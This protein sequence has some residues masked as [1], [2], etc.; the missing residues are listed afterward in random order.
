MPKSFSTIKR[1][2]SADEKRERALDFN[3][4]GDGFVDVEA[5][6]KKDIFKESI[7]LKCLKCDYQEEVDYDIVSEC[8]DDS[9]SPYPISY[10]PHC[11][12]D[13]FVPLDIYNQLKK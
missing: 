2:L 12:R 5:F 10:C 9:E 1:P 11:G 7:F 8:W 4:Y 3:S 13:K 6:V